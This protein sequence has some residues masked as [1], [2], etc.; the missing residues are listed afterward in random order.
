MDDVVGDSTQRIRLDI[1]L[2]RAQASLA[3]LSL[4]DAAFEL[5]EQ[6]V[7][8]IRTTSQ[9]EAAKLPPLFTFAPSTETYTT[10][11]YI[12]DNDAATLRIVEVV[13]GHELVQTGDAFAPADGYA[14]VS[15]GTTTHTGSTIVVTIDTADANHDTANNAT[16]FVA[17]AANGD[18]ADYAAEVVGYIPPLA[19]E[20]SYRFIVFDD[21]RLELEEPLLL[22]SY[23]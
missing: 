8:A 4:T 12:V 15:L 23:R 21:G 2:V 11:T 3:F 7:A 6:V 5:T 22:A 19:R 20:T 1:P 9:I 10:T 14:V 13:V 16:L 18:K 17:S